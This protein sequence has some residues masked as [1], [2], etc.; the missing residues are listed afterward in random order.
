MIASD[1]TSSASPENRKG[2]PWIG[3]YQSV[4]CRKNSCDIRRRILATER[5]RQSFSTLMTVLMSKPGRFGDR[6]GD[7]RTGI[8]SAEMER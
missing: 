1:R 3:R 6:L 2:S 7:D 8:N 4:P 5:R